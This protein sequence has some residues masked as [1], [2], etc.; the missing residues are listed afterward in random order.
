MSMRARQMGDVE[1]VA[2]FAGEQLHG[3]G[4]EVHFDVPDGDGGAVCWAALCCPH[5]EPG[6]N[7]IPRDAGRLPFVKQRR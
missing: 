4:Q 3:G 7:K 6:L 5:A 2:A 1:L